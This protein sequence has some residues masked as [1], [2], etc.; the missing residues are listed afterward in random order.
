ML[1]A[2]EIH[3]LTDF[4][5]NHKAH[6]KR[7]KETHVPEVLTVNGRAEVVML[8]VDSFQELMEKLEEAET[9]AAIREGLADAE[10][11]RVAPAEQFFAE[12]RAKYDIQD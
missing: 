3:P 12:M 7:L 1:D 5:H 2:R 4:L 8:D 6:I 11:G 9:L 10:A